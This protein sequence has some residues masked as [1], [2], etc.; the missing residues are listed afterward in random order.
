LTYDA[1]LD[2]LF[3]EL[4]TLDRTCLDTFWLKDKSLTD[5]DTLS[6]PDVLEDEIIENQE[7]G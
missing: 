2:A 3:G 4:I 5:I 6:E 7:A 1:G